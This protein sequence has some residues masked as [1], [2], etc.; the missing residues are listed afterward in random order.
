MEL[1]D[2]LKRWYQEDQDRNAESSRSSSITSAPLEDDH[3]TQW[4]NSTAKSKF[5]ASRDVS[6]IDKYLRLEP[7]V[8]HEP[9]QW[10][11]DHW[12]TF[13]ALSQFALDVFAIPAMAADCERQF[14]LAK[15]TLTSQRL[16]MGAETLERVHCLRNWVR[17][18]GVRLGNWNGNQTSHANPS[19][20]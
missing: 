6:E 14:S 1:N 12:Q 16:A 7:H 19:D 15:L 18:G 9:I 3:Y 13:P 8:T 10:W 17:R 2:Y 11:V 4:I 20:S 5:A